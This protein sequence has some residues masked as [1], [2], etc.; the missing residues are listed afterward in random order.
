[1]KLKKALDAVDQ[2]EEMLDDLS[3]SMVSLLHSKRA[4]DA[5]FR[6]SAENVVCMQN[7]LDEVMDESDDFDDFRQKVF[8]NLIEN[9][10]WFEHEM[11]GPLIHDLI[12]S[13]Y[14]NRERKQTWLNCD[15]KNWPKEL[16][17]IE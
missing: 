12:R 5:S 17:Y 1:M 13:Y 16:I 15:L 3:I 2:I 11:Y 4:T 14:R 7:M 8:N 9:N 6:V 10:E